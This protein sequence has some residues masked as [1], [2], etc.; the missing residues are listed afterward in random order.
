MNTSGSSSTTNQPPSVLNSPPIAPFSGIASLASLALATSSSSGSNNDTS[1]NINW[2]TTSLSPSL[3]SSH[4]PLNI[5]EPSPLDPDHQLPSF[6]SMQDLPHEQFDPSAT[7]WTLSTDDAKV[8]GEP[9]GS[10]SV[11]VVKSW[12]MMGVD[13][14]AV[15]IEI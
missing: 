14:V 9:E 6:A 1:D 4:P 8:L 7:D 11:G 13:V 5:D 15:A 12:R 10:V 3:H 2:A